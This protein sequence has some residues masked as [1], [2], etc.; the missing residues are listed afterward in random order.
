MS[1]RQ[2]IRH[3]GIL[4]WKLPFISRHMRRLATR[5]ID[6][7]RLFHGVEAML[8][9]LDRQGIV[10]AAV[11]S[12]SEANVRRVLGP[13]GWRFRHFACG[14]ALF[15][16]AKRLRQVMKVCGAS[17]GETLAIGDEIRDL[18][19]ARKVG[20]AFGAVGWGY[21]RGDALSAQQPDYVF[22]SPAD[23]VGRITRPD[24]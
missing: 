24:A 8:I 15:R 20:C 18:E 1:A 6:S 22:T 9:E 19:A 21:T 5:D 17:P 3:V 13:L 10:L 2:A 7:V 12:N 23:I 4:A 11:S 16:K 14:A